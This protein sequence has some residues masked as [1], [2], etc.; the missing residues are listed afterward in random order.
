MKR[1][2]WSL[3][4]IQQKSLGLIRLLISFLNLNKKKGLLKN[5]QVRVKS[6]HAIVALTIFTT[7]ATL[8]FEFAGTRRT[9]KKKKTQMKLS[10]T[11]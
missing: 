7:M 9:K 6:Q 4:R 1:S 11:A 5:D 3:G 10:L 2:I 8:L